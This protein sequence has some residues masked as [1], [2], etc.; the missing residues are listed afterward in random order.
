MDPTSTTTARMLPGKPVADAIFDQIKQEVDPARR[1]AETLNAARIIL[2]DAPIVPLVEWTTHIIQKTSVKIA[3][4]A[5]SIA[6]DSW[7]DIS[8]S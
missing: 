7:G 6:T 1:K 4:K 8:K 5:A 2:R 3:S